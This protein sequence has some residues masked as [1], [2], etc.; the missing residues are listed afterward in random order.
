[1][2]NIEEVRAGIALATDKIS[3]SF[4]PLQQAHAQISEAQGL[5][6]R[7]TEGTGQADVQEAVGLLAQALGSITDGQQAAKAA[8]SS[9]EAIANRL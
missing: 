5:L 7:V 1:M 3:E 9:S 8:V 2:A 6:L 4:G